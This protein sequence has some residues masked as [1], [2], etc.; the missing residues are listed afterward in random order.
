MPTITRLGEPTGAPSTDDL[1][2]WVRVQ[3]DPSMRTWVQHT[4]ADGT[5]MAGTWESDVGTW[6]ATYTEYEYVHLLQGRIVITEDGG[7]PVTVR[8]GDAFAVEAGF[9]GTWR[10][11][12]PVR[13]H[14]AFRLK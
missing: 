9:R 8:A 1:E 2:G 11:E 6:H 10:V 5:M 4:S 13:K 12:E 7:E 3:G 14:W